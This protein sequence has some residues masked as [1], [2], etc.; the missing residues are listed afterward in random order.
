MQVQCNRMHP[1][2]I[3]SNAS[4]NAMTIGKWNP[5]QGYKSKKKYRPKFEGN[6]FNLMQCHAC[7]AIECIHQ[8][9]RMCA[10]AVCATDLEYAT[11]SVTSACCR[12]GPVSIYPSHPFVFF[13]LSFCRGVGLEADADGNYFVCTGAD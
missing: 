9:N 7:N 3:G 11:T 4:N 6:K 5:R 12:L 13:F 10:L 1:P 8:C 2:T